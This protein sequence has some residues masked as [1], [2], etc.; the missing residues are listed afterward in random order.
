MALT[1]TPGSIR[2][3]RQT[4]VSSSILE[5]FINIVQQLQEDN[6]QLQLMVGDMKRQIGHNVTTLESTRQ[7][8]A[9]QPRGYVSA[10]DTRVSTPLTTQRFPLRQM[11]HKISSMQDAVE[12]W[13][14]PPPP[15]FLQRDHPNLP[16]VQSVPPPPLPP[17][18]SRSMKRDKRSTKRSTTMLLGVTHNA[19]PERSS[20]IIPSTSEVQDKPTTYCP[21]FNN[22]LHFLNQCVNFKMLSKEQKYIWIKSNNLYWHLEALHEVNHRP[23]AP[24]LPMEVAEL[25]SKPSTDVLYRNQHAGCSQVILKIIKVLLQNG[26]DTLE[27]FAI[28]DD[29]SE[30]MILR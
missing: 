20:A 19:A 10:D 28:L 26:E 25:G 14:V 8:S 17:R 5:E 4:P 15:V 30:R 27:T 24:N 1:Q 11:Q 22:T 7:H 6:R 21:Y 16:E 12:E 2:A 18:D 29:G 9:Q 13:S 3:A 23:A